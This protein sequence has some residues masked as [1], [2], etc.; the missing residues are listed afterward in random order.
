MG[1]LFISIID[2]RNLTS[3]RRVAKGSKG[4]PMMVKGCYL[5]AEDVGTKDT[6]CPTA[7]GA[8]QAPFSCKIE[9]GSRIVSEVRQRKLANAQVS[10]DAPSDVNRT[11]FE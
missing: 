5:R 1:S 3:C 6:K 8:S 11:G 10:R 7:S 9:K 4:F 2:A